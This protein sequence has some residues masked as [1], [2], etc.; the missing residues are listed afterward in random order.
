MSISRDW[1]WWRASALVACVAILVGKLALVFR[2]NIN[3]DE[4][5]FL[6]NVHSLVRGDLALLLQGSYTHL[7]VWLASLAGDEMLQLHAARIVCWFLF[8]V[9][10]GLLYRLAALLV[11]PRHAVLAVLAYLAASPVLVH[12][13]SFRADSLLLPLTLAGLLAL[14]LPGA[15]T[16]QRVAAGIAFGVA[17]AISVK[18]ALLAPTVVLLAVATV[19]RRHA[20]TAFAW[21]ELL[22][23]LA[24]VALVA[25]T[26]A[27]VLLALH[28]WT[29]PAVP[30]ASA[31]TH[32]T[33]ALRTTLLEVPWLPRAAYFDATLD[34]D[35]VTWWLCLAGSVVALWS[36]RWAVVA[37]VLSLAPILFYRNAF[38]YYYVVML[39]PACIAVAAA[40]DWIE[41]RL[42]LRGNGRLAHF[43]CGVLLLALSLQ[44]VNTLQYLRH[45]DQAAQRAVIAA[46]HRIFPEPVPYID[47][48]GMVASFPKV[49]P[50][51]STWGV[52]AYRSTGVPFV[53]EAF[54]REPP[55]LLLANRPVIDP[56]SP[57][58]RQL[59][60]EDRER[61]LQ[62]YVRYWGPV[63]VAG[64]ELPLARR[65]AVSTR[66]PFAGRYR[67]EA[68]AAVLVDAT[69]VPPG[70]TVELGAAPVSLAW[71][72]VPFADGKVRLVWADAEPPPRESP[73]VGALY[74]GL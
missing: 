43:A 68:A 59:L 16:R 11:S 62:S 18:A 60:P 6:S 25:A 29:L 66:V 2:V 50:F 22:R 42:A 47:H 19:A 61:I 40:T 37:C 30:A 21:R 56:A 13:A 10:A 65:G 7:F 74:R 14:A 28:A 31:S 35:P 20:A 52:A 70:G 15:G 9:A 38:P 33:A 55:P 58:L 44:A 41:R 49:G 23:E 12:G 27:A 72:S 53:A 45:D 64:V 67:V 36:R 5:Y 54:Q 46:V 63:W 69:V 48:S 8:V 51:L 57:V 26:T 73:P 24:T 32:A 3:W 39:A 17:A 34:A 4:F 1:P 71:A